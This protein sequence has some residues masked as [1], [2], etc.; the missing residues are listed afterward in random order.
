MRREFILLLLGIISVSTLS[1]FLSS[2]MEP[3]IPDKILLDTVDGFVWA[4][5]FSYWQLGYV[6]PLLIE[7]TSLNGDA[8]LY[9]SDTIRPSYEVDKNNFSSATCGTDVVHIPMEFPRPIG[10][11]VFGDWSSSISEYVIQVFLDGNAVM[12]FTEEQLLAI[13]Q[14]QST[15]SEKTDNNQR[16]G[17]KVVPRKMD[18][19]K[20]R[21]VKLINI[22]DMIFEMFVL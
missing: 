6:G 5:N 9:V 19:E 14:S 8:D 20:P 3:V 2:Y 1:S 16:I 17:E 4:G 22:L 7:L 15:G 13:E 11:G 12:R 10:I 18:E 21:F